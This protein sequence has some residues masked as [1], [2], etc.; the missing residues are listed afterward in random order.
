MIRPGY[1]LIFL[2]ITALH[3]SCGRNV[4]DPQFSVDMQQNSNT[5]GTKIVSHA[6]RFTIERQDGYSKLTVIDPWQGAQGINHTYYLVSRGTEIPDGIDP[7]GIIF[8]PV[9]KIVC[10]STTHL[11]MISALDED[12]SIVAVSGAE[13]IYDKELSGKAHNHEIYDVGYEAGLNSE[14]VIRISP[15]LIMMYGIGSESAGHVNKIRELGFSIIFNADY[16]EN[17]PLGKAE[18]IRLF[19]ALYCKEA[20]A[21]SIF[22]EISADY[23][24]IKKIIKE[25]TYDRPKV[26]LGLPYK[27]TWF[28]SPGNSYISKIIADAGGDYLWTDIESSFSMPYG[29]ENVYLKAVT[30]DYWLNTGIARSKGEISAVDPRLAGIQCFKRGNI[31]NNDKRINEKG[32]NDYWESGSLYPNLILRDIASILHP[33]ILAPYDL[34]YYRKLN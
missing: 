28:I 17:D 12:E 19:G 32:G 26:M 7:A 6:E 1:I 20:M 5:A 22:N 9:Q 8:V 30:A 15:D 11:A 34:Y 16:L 23:L 27:D 29:I 10:M 33:G 4:A 2:L 18:W 21:D 13:F 31:F 24:S 25:K 3:Y 14:L